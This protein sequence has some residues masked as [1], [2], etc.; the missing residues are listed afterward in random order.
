MKTCYVYIMA[1]RRNGTLYTG[2]TNNLVRRVWEHKEGIIKGF[3]QKYGVKILVWYEVF[4]SVES[5][6]MQEKNIKKWKRNWKLRLIEEMNPDW[7]DLYD[8]IA[9]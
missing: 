3:T 6:I 7:N 2:M 9:A 1:S 5:A 4:D 8:G